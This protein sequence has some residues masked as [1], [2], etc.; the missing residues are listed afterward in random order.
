LTID[1]FTVAFAYVIAL[2]VIMQQ[3]MEV[4]ERPPPH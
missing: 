3:P 1:F 4:S 2:E